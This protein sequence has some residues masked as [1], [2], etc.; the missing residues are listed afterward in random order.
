[1]PLAAM[2]R[3]ALAIASGNA[4]AGADGLGAAVSVASTSA[5]SSFI[6]DAIASAA[7]PL[8]AI[9][10][11]AFAIGAGRVSAVPLA[12][13]AVDASTVDAAAAAVAAVPSPSVAA[14]LPLVMVTAGSKGQRATLSVS[15][16]GSDQPDF[17]SSRAFGP[18]PAHSS[19]AAVVCTCE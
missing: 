18:S 15:G 17:S 1:M 2:V 4:L 10:F 12:A 19:R 9:V 3:T 8:A 16:V 7:M 6:T 11:T 5:A 14:P 13:E